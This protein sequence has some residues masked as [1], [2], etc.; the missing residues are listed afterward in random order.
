[1]CT[2]PRLIDLHAALHTAEAHHAADNGAGQPG[3]GPNPARV[4]ERATRLLEEAASHAALLPRAEPLVPLT[5]LLGDR[6]RARLLGAV[7]GSGQVAAADK[8][9]GDAQQE[10]ARKA[11]LRC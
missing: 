6:R 10:K 9:A 2:S 5:A 8:A 1:M 7:E 11:E 4:V 3:G